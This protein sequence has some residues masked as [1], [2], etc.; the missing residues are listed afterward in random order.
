MYNWISLLLDAIYRN[1][2]E[3]HGY[4]LSIA[5]QVHGFCQ[6][7]CGQ[8]EMLPNRGDKILC[9]IP[10]KTWLVCFL[11]YELGS[12]CHWL[13]VV[14]QNRW[15]V[16]PKSNIFLELGDASFSM[17][18]CFLWSCLLLPFPHS[19][20]FGIF[21]KCQTK[22]LK[23]LFSKPSWLVLTKSLTS[24]LYSYIKIYSRWIQNLNVKKPLKFYMNLRSQKEK[25]R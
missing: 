12:G 11:F 1:L 19:L 13:C 10:I 17:Q 25:Y 9:V 24:Q 20:I 8:D 18:L 23:T 2:I 15:L 21:P 4:L 16:Y 3:P 7:E 5:P 14:F 6:S 22:R